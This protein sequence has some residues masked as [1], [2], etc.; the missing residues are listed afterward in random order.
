MVF[1]DA[2]IASALGWE[3]ILWIGLLSIDPEIFITFSKKSGI[4]LN[5][6]LL[7]ILVDTLNNDPV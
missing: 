3:I 6:V 5:S 1:S 4:F 7:S 2:L